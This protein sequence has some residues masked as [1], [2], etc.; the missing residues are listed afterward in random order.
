MPVVVVVEGPVTVVV[1][2]PVVVESVTVVVDSAH[3]F[4]VRSQTSMTIHYI[5]YPFHAHS[6]V[7]FIKSVRVGIK[8]K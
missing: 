5:F 1:E 4:T 8:I 2:G 3:R 6:H 7:L